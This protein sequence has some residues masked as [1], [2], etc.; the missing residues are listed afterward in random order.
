MESIYERPSRLRAQNLSQRVNKMEPVTAVEG[1]AKAAA[2]VGGKRNAWMTHLKKTMRANKGKSLSQVM[3]MAK[4]TYKKTAKRGGAL[5][6]ALYKGGK[7]G[8]R[9]KSLSR[10]PIY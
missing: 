8:S 5:S 10:K 9:S 4:K 2:V 1:A 7:K 3:K 6:P